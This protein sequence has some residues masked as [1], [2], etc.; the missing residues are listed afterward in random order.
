MKF[1]EQAQFDCED[2]AFA[3]IHGLHLGAHK[4]YI[5][6][7]HQMDHYIEEFIFDAFISGIKIGV[8]YRGK[9]LDAEFD[10]M[11]GFN[12]EYWISQ[13]LF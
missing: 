5:A 12:V 4:A 11:D 3:F 1:K 10:P 2:A 9:L 8:K 6:D 13:N 7:K